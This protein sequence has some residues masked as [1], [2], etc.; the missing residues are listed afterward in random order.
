MSVITLPKSA[1]TAKLRELGRLQDIPVVRQLGSLLLIAATIALGLWLFFWTQKP[2]YVPV[3]AGLDAK[4]SNDAA[5]LLRQQKIPFKV[6]ENGTLAV[7]QEQIGA[8]R[9]ALAG[10]GLT[11][12]PSS[13]IDTLGKDGSFGSSQFMENARYQR[14]I[15]TDLARTIATLQ[16]VRDARV[17]LAV[18]KPSAF[19]RQ[20]EPAGASVVIELNSG[21]ALDQGQV[22]AIVHL[23]SSSIPSLPPERV[24]VVD[25]FGRMLSSQGQNGDDAANN[26]KFEQQRRLESVYV[27]RIRELLEPMTGTGRVSAQVSVQMDFSQTEQ[28][29][30]TYGPQTPVVRSEQVS[31]SGNLSTANAQGPNGVPGSASNTPGATTGNPA[32]P[33]SGGGQGSRNAV[34]N[35]E[36]D[37]TLTHTRQE[38]G[39]VQ[40]VTAAVLVDNIASGTADKNGKVPTRA[41]NAAELQNIQKLVEQ[42]V[43]FDAQRG[44][45]ISVVNAPFARPELADDEKSGMFPFS[46]N[47]PASRDLLRIGV[48]GIALIVLILTVLRPALRNLLGPKMKQKALITKAPEAKPD[49]GDDEDLKVTLQSKTRE[50]LN[51]QPAPS[52]EVLE[53]HVDRARKAVADDPRRVA[54][55]IRGWVDGDE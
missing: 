3:S 49:T 18:P 15:E 45:N 1:D 34:R 4:S 40:R 55:V 46:L 41:L 19:S 17:H 31:E 14:A 29:Q 11:G 52:N 37:R 27:Q 35:Y 54:E 28:A 7:P 22:N 39:R 44:D 23:V 53:N 50:T 30:E 21:A 42:A 51:L 10:G 25:Q 36:I 5:E 8:A 33:A 13:G 43:G 38:P 47:D 9:M 12:T 24:T 6:Q 48:G 20:Q 16:P 32:P 2:D 26:R